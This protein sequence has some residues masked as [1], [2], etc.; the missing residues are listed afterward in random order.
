MEDVREENKL[1]KE[2]VMFL[3]NMMSKKNNT[4]TNN[5]NIN[6]YNNTKFNEMEAQFNI[7]IRDNQMKDEKIRG[8]VS[9]NDILK[10][11]KININNRKSRRWTHLKRRD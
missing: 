7:S 9:A 10:N 6:L 11:V 3:E 8:L 5:I 2:K 1:L 4:N